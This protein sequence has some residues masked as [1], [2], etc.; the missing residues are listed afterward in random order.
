[1]VLFCSFSRIKQ[2]I[3]NQADLNVLLQLHVINVE[4]EFRHN[5][6]EEEDNF[7]FQEKQ[8]R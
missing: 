2:T 4:D 6:A 8:D 5:G 1:M 3:T 7:S